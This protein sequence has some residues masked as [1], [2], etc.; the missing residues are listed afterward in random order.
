MVIDQYQEI[1]E[2]LEVV[3]QHHE[4]SLNG[5]K[6]KPLQQIR[7]KAM[8]ALNEHAFPT[9]KSEDWKYTAVSPII[10]PA[11]Q[12]PTK[13]DSATLPTE[14]VNPMRLENAIR[15]VYVDGHLMHSLSYLN[16]SVE[17]LNFMTIDDAMD[18]PN[19]AEFIESKL[20]YKIAHPLN[21]FELMN[22]AF[23]SN[24]IVIHVSKNAIID[25]PIEFV[26]LN[27]DQDQPYFV[28]PT[29]LLQAEK[30]SQV[31]IIERF[32]DAENASSIF[33]NAMH[34]FDIDENARVDYTKIQRESHSTFHLHQIS[35]S[36]K[37]DSR[38]YSYVSDIG[39][40][41]VRNNHSTYLKGQNTETHLL[42][43][44]IASDQ[45]SIDNQ[46]FI[47]HAMPNCYSNELYKGIVAGRAKG[48]FNGKIL[49]RPDAQKTNAF[50]QNAN[51]ILSPHAVVDAKPQLE[52]FADDVKCSHGATIGQ[53][54]EESIFY[55]KTR[56]LSDHDAKRMLQKAFV[57]EVVDHIEHEAINA[58]AHEIVEKKISGISAQ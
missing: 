23:G 41:T 4:T 45:Q 53:L 32:E 3:F 6:E 55:L 38:F 47:D 11:Y 26:Y 44:Y 43:T 54:D 24:G 17:G 8:K 13:P 18:I 16:D 30:S 25:R 42:G 19:M 27:R 49:V 15:I 40:K 37:S 7:R 39:G 29:I 57:N 51:M 20:N 34:F 56:G 48:I 50:Q 21:T 9:R 2:R 12:I 58:F 52:I 22:I 14:L 36:Q 31:R 46:T 1:K 5:R 28:H 10:K 35:N 33:T